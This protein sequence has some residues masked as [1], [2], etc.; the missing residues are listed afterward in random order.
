M[1]HG[2]LVKSAERSFQ[3]PGDTR[4]ISTFRSF[5]YEAK[6]LSGCLFAPRFH[7]RRVKGRTSPADLSEGGS[8]VRYELPRILAAQISLMDR[9]WEAE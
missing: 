6:H 4:H 1:L 9:R 2:G 8:F 5:A 7:A 3:P